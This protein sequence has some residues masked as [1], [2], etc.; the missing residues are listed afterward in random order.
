M[1]NNIF[2]SKCPAVIRMDPNSPQELIKTEQAIKWFQNF[3][4]LSRDNTGLNNGFVENLNRGHYLLDLERHWYQFIL[5]K[6]DSPLILSRA[7]HMWISNSGTQPIIWQVDERHLKL[8]D[9]NTNRLSST[10]L[11]RNLAGNSSLL[12]WSPGHYECPQQLTTCYFCQYNW[13]RC[14]WLFR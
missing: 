13:S 6:L 10:K 4:E 9:H 8:W 12:R 11:W 7:D 1:S 3:G 2:Q 14:P 5:R